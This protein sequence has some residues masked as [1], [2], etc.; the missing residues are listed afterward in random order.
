MN[1]VMAKI[2]KIIARQVL[3]SRGNPTVEAEIL[4]NDFSVTGIVPSGASTGIHEAHELRDNG[5]SYNGK[6]V[7]KAVENVNRIISKKLV[8]KDCTK[9]SEIDNLMIS[10]DG[11]KNKT[12]LGANAILAVSIAVCKAGAISQKIPLYKYISKIAGTTPSMPIPQMNIINSGKHVGVDNDVQ[13]HMILPVKFNSFSEKLR[14]GT[15]TYHALKKILKEKFGARATLL[16]DEGGF[17]PE[18]K[19]V[20]ERLAIIVEAINKAG[21]SGKI[22]LGLDPASSEF[23]DKDSGKYTILDRRFSK[24]QLADYYSELC[25]KFPITTIEDGFSEDD[26]EGWRLMNEK[27]GK[28]IQ[29]VGDD[30]LV[31]NPSRIELAVKNKSCNALLLKVNQ[32]GT[33]T[34]S[35]SAAKLA[36]KNKW[37]VVVSHRSGESEDAFIADLAVG[38]GAEQVKFGAPARSERIAKYNQLLRIEEK[39]R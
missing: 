37:S 6:G 12:K 23:Y 21:Y 25:N 30:L 1:Q 11:T 10:L 29:L 15:E 8:G 39:I 38:I 5:K 19:T 33:V 22:F 2:K 18:I 32:I 4:V 26:F 28:K 35:I 17:A 14:A 36:M 13:E 34:E 3:D 7:L 31:T 20:E 16:G 24:K 27:L 9:Q